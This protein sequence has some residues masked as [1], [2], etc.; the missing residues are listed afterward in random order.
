MG[1][2]AQA[3]PSSQLGAESGT[4]SLKVADQFRTL[5]HRMSDTDSPNYVRIVQ[6]IHKIQM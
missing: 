4:M 1:S 6:R 2:L 3:K 5:M